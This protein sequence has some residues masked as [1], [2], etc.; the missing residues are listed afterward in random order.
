MQALSPRSASS[1]NA[2]PAPL[3]FNPRPTGKGTTGNVNALYQ[4][5]FSKAVFNSS[6]WCALLLP[7]PHLSS[8]TSPSPHLAA[9][10]AEARQPS[11]DEDEDEEDDLDLLGRG[12]EED[13]STSPTIHLVYIPYCAITATP[14]SQNLAARSSLFCSGYLKYNNYD[15]LASSPIW[16]LNTLAAAST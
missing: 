10:A 1:I 16:A 6:T 7:P 12:H 4:G 3:E 5:G 8:P 13:Q 11:E 2:L 9:P 15:G 14:T